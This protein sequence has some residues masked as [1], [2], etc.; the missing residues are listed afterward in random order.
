MNITECFW[1][2]C[3][4]ITT[5]TTSIDCAVLHIIVTFMI[6]SCKTILANTRTVA[7]YTVVT[8]IRDA[9]LFLIHYFRTD[10]TGN[11]I[12]YG[13]RPIKY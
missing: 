7:L 8:S 6:S 1:I 5:V 10:G 3:L 11:W 4:L 9:V 13:I 2:P 12:F